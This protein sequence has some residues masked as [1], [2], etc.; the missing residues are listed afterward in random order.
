MPSAIEINQEITNGGPIGVL[1]KYIRQFQN[2]RN[3]NVIVYYSD[4][5][6]GSKNTSIQDED[7][8]GFM[9]AVYRMDKSKGLDLF[10]HTPG[11][12]VSA[13]EGIGNYLRS[14]FNGDIECFVPHMAMS[15]GTLLAMATRKIHM[16]KHSCIGPFDPALG[17]YRADAVIEE[18]AKAKSDIASNPH[19]A[20]LWQPIIS[21][22]PITFL[23]EC[24]KAKEMAVIVSRKWLSEGMFLG[25]EKLGQKIESV[26]DTFAN[27]MNSKS[28]DRHISAEE[29][30]KTGLNVSLI[31]SNSTLQDN[32]MSVHH[33]AITYIKSENI[34]RV[35]T[36][37]EGRGLFVS[38]QR[39]Q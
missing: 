9:S 14:V 3:R 15:C 23:G 12:S 31:E 29:A 20:L 28:H 36:N 4:F 7:M 16:G 21:K 17:K 37:V 18:F 10:I 32:V 35:V 8:T 25:D 27:H 24:E 30:I 1:F 22:Y 33:A 11:G 38:C 6:S 5:L 2:W 26:L 34:A 13:T 39:E 19:L